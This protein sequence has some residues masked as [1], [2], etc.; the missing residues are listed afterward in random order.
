M[1]P[2]PAEQQLLLNHLIQLM[3][4]EPAEQ[5]LLLSP[6]NP[7]NTPGTGGTTIAPEP[8]NPTNAPG[9]GGTTVAPEPSGPTNAPGTTTTTT[10]APGTGS[11][12]PEPDIKCATTGFM[13]KTGNCYQFVYC[14]EDNEGDLHP[15]IQKC[16]NG[17]QF[18]PGCGFCRS[19]YDC[20]KPSPNGECIVEQ[21]K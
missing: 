12:T 7:T 3:L 6:S 13:P 1:L 18:D 15:I 5:R 11:T 10:D 14:Y 21:E 20:T 2:E 8:S 17:Q 16:I 9:T 19:N 4:P